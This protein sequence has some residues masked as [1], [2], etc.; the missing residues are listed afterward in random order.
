MKK[1]TLLCSLLLSAAGMQAQ[2][3]YDFSTTQAAYADLQNA[4]SINEGEVWDWDYFGEFAMPFEF[5]IA[6]E[7]VNRFL[8]EDDYFAFLTP[9]AN[10]EED[11]IEGVFL[12]YPTSIFIQDRTYSTNTSSTPISYKVDGTVGNR[13]LKLEVKNAGAESA[14]FIG[15]DEDDYYMNFQIWLYESDDTIEIRYGTS[16]IDQAFLTAD[17]EPLIVAVFGEVDGYILSGQSTSPTYGEYTEETFEEGITLDAYPAN[18]TVYKFTP[19][20]VA[21]NDAFSKQALTVY[22]NPASSVLNLKTDNITAT[23]YTISNIMGAVVGHDKIS[24]PANAQINVQALQD[25]LYY[26]KVGDQSIKFIKKQ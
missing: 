24:N 12:I 9:G 8:F 7:P 16:N 3:E 23:E 13:I 6:G 11:D 25:G 15:F 26:I 10:Y 18:G 17:G 21:G 1:I 14:S 4:T 5:S 22:P 2:N 20:V 19:H